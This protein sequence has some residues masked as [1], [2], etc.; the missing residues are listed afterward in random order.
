MTD[1][2][3]LHREGLLAHY[4]VP[5]ST[6]PLEGSKTKVQLLKRQAFSFRDRAFFKRIYALQEAR[7]FFIG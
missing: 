2:L 1:T 3:S 6:G 7:L 4:D 5:V